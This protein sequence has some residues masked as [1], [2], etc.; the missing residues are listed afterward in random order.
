[1]SD[2]PTMNIDLHDHTN[3]KISIIIVHYDRPSYLNI[4]LQSIYVMSNLN[5][6]EIIVVDN[7]SGQ[8][9][10]DFLKQLEEDG[11]KVIRNKENKHFSVAAN[12][13][14]LATDPGSKYF[15]FMHCDTVVLKQ[16][17]LDVLVNGSET[18][19][20]GM[21]GVDMQHVSM[22]S[23]KIDYIPEWCVLFTRECWNDCGPW[24]EEL[25]IVGQSFIMTLRAVW[26]GYKPQAIKQDTVA[27]YKAFAYDPRSWGKINEE[28]N[29]IIPKL[30][31][32]A[33]NSAKN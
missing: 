31:Q 6:Y 15:V 16:V 10:Q 19:E 21:V 26:R 7:N 33:R 4:L 14:A 23:E 24:P 28:A 13:G 20:S 9:T 18:G 3:A 17:W 2:N 22:N 12:Q 8:E 27:H 25:P 29:A 5:N 1:M 30:M 32:K 11:I